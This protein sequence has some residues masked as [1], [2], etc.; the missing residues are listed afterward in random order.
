MENIKN[1]EKFAA[2]YLPEG[3][4]ARLGRTLSAPAMF[5]LTGDEGAEGEGAEGE[6]AAAPQ[7][8]EKALGN[9]QLARDCETER[10]AAKKWCPTD[11]TSSKCYDEISKKTCEE[12]DEWVKEEK[13][14]E[15]QEMID[16]LKL[17]NDRV[18]ELEDKLTS[19]DQ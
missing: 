7:P 10:R 8:S 14:K 9:S 16:Q 15:A 3:T 12:L 6:G 4:V 1:I 5:M 18:K 17:L 2:R 19:K 13:H 11:N